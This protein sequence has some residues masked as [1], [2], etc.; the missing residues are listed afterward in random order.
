MEVNFVNLVIFLA[1]VGLVFWGMGWLLEHKCP[2][3]NPLTL[4]W[5]T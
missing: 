1:V 4:S 3:V 5:R 2:L